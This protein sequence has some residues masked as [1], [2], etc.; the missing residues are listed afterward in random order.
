MRLT[1][2]IFNLHKATRTKFLY[3]LENLSPAQLSQIPDGFRNNIY[4]NIA[5]SVATQQILCY[6]LSGLPTVVSDNFIDTYRKGTVPKGDVPSNE[7]ILK[8]K[9]ILSLTQQKLEED[10]K[11]GLFKNFTSYATSYGFELSSIEDAITFNNVHESMH[12]GVVIAL[13]YFC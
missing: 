3:H 13:N 10:Y 9:E 4:W 6:K 11:Q 5:H 8:L 2:Q 12:L 1:E 7:D